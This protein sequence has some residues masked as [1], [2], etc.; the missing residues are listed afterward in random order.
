ML[1][2]QR[3]GCNEDEVGCYAHRR[4]ASKFSLQTL[5][6]VNA[7]SWPQNQKNPLQNRACN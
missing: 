3:G 5:G 4:V 1:D 2:L 7:N 6:I